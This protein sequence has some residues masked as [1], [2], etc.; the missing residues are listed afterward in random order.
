MTKP[1]VEKVPAAEDRTLPIFEEIEE[2]TERIRNR[3]YDFFRSHGF[4]DGHA[5]EDWLKAER[6]I[7][8]PEAELVE[9][10]EGFTLKIS[11]AGFDGDDI[12][13]TA[14]PSEIIVKAVQESETPAESSEEEAPETVHWSD[15]RY[16]N[17][18]RKV[19]LPIDVAVNKVKANLKDGM[20]TVTAPKLESAR[21][22]KPKK[23][24]I[25]TAA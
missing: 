21:K 11:L 15:F 7:C 9:G 5:L 4:G 17:V 2:I 8:W 14:T 16:E 24:E 18:Y 19:E 12:T 1:K 13:V 10:D 25:S 3:A 20:L 6:E 22:P 23:V